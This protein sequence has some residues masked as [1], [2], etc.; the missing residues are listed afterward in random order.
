MKEK[1]I[2]EWLPYIIIVIVVI[3]IRSY[4]VTPVIVKGSSMEDTLLDG[5]V[6]FLSKISYRVSDIKRFDIVV[7]KDYD[8]D[9][10]IKRVIGL[11]GDRV[12]YDE[13]GLYINGKKVKDIYAN[14]ETSYFDVDSICDING[15]TCNGVI[16]KDKY[17]VLGDNREVS[18]D[19][20]VKG[21]FS[22]SDIKGKA[23]VRVWP[24]TKIKILNK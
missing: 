4:I 24:L 19:S 9:L 11:P 1:F 10:I 5:E 2:K 3:F 20:R 7:I 18:A 8:K 13:N 16:P 23:I 17:L 6:L 15:I 14:N 12:S 22:S 21:L